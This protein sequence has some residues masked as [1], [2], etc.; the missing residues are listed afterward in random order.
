MAKN[1]KLRYAVSRP[2]IGGVKQA[3]LTME[4]DRKKPLLLVVHGGPGE[5]VIPFADSLSGLEERFVVCLWE[6]RNAG[7]SYSGEKDLRIPQFVSDTVEVTKHLLA[8]FNRQKLV[9]MGFSWGTLLGI[10]AAA[11]T[12]ELY[13]AFV[14]VGQLADQLSSEKDAYDAA[15]E[16]SQTAGDKK[17]ADALKEIGPPPYSGKGGM[18]ILMKE[19]AILRKYS[20]N[21]A[22]SPKMSNYLKKVFSCPYYTLGDKINFLR[23]M[24]S[25]ASL[26]SQV[27]EIDVLKSVPKISA[28]VYVMQGKHDMQTMPRHAKKLIDRLDAPKKGFF[29]FEKAGHS[30]LDD[31]PQEFFRALDS[32]DG[33]FDP[34]TE[35]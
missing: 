1:E 10:F 33:M 35:N 12:P 14:G 22:K 28:P 18:K 17:S 19:R 31:D 8:R 23:G 34:W 16:R 13:S 4:D 3:V 7:M 15:L 6:Q 29:L 21:P 11:R 9:L 26:F 2:V 5:P 24:T 25:G 20:G 32:I 27:L 30:P